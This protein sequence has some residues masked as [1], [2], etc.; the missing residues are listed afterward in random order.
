MNGFTVGAVRDFVKKEENV[1]KIVKDTQEPDFFWW[2]SFDDPYVPF[3]WEVV[4]PE[5]APQ[6]AWDS[7]IP[8]QEDQENV[9]P[10]AFIRVLFAR[11]SYRRF[12]LTDFWEVEIGAQTRWFPVFFSKKFGSKSEPCVGTAHGETFWGPAKKGERADAWYYSRHHSG[13]AGHNQKLL[14]KIYWNFVERGPY[15]FFPSHE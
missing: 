1:A 5:N 6:E 11:R 12:E 7:I 9:I 3:A 4:N 2:G 8:I 14:R 15:R 13:P 10:L